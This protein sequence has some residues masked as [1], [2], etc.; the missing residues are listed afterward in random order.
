MNRHIDPPQWVTRRSEC[1]ISHKFEAL[2]EIARRDADEANALDSKLRKDCTFKFVEH[3]DGVFRKFE[4]VRY[5]KQGQEDGSVIFRELDASIE[6]EY[7]PTSKK[8]VYSV[9]PEWDSEKGDCVLRIDN[10]DREFQVW[11]VSQHFIGPLIFRDLK[12]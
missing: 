2:S 12:V 11:E 5:P 10:R 7:T 1:N 9:R 3:P 6:V 4:V 8:A